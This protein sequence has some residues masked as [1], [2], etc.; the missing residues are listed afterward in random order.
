MEHKK[1]Q[2]VFSSQIILFFS[3]PEATARQAA[4]TIAA[5]I[6]NTL[7]YW[8]VDEVKAL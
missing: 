6:V 3:I 1:H 8:P 5:L 4:M 7:E 2:G